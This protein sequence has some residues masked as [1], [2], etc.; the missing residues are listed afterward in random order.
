MKL[1]ICIITYLRPNSLKRLL[2]AISVLEFRQVSPPDIEVVIVDNDPEQSAQ[3]TFSA[4]Y[5]EFPHR[6]SYSVEPQ[7]GIPFARNR[8]VLSASA[9][10]DFFVF[11]DDDEVP[12][13]LWLDTL[14]VVQSHPIAK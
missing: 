8:S 1:S 2:A 13:P 7:R 4:V 11:I 3:P 12:A 5:S 9:D 6:I 14:L 10:S